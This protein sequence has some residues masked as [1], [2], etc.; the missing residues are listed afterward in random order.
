MQKKTYNS[1]IRLQQERAAA[2]KKKEDTLKTVL[3][4]AKKNPKFIKLLIYSL[5]SLENF[6]SPPN[7]E[8]PINAKII[9]R[10]EG[11]GILRALALINITND[12]VVLKTGDIIWK[13]ISVYD[14][15]DYELAKYFAEK[16]GHQAA[17]EI[18]ISKNK[19]STDNES[20]AK[21][22]IPFIKV[23]NGL[24]QIPQLMNKLLENNL[25][26]TIKLIND[27]YIDDINILN[28]NSD[29]T[30]KVSNLK[31]G[32]D[33]ILK[34]GLIP[35]ILKNL[36][37][38][39]QNRQ[40][41]SVINNFTTLENIARNDEGKNEIK[42]CD[43]IKIIAEV[44]D[45]F[46]END[47]I[48]GKGEK[49]YTKI[50]TE[51]DVK[52]LVENLKNAN[53]ENLG[54][55]KLIMLILSNVVLVEEFAKIVYEN[56]NVIIDVYN[57]V[58]KNKSD[59]ENLLLILRYF[60]ILF[61]RIFAYY[62]NEYYYSNNNKELISNITKSI[63]LIP[64]TFSCKNFNDF[65][66]AYASLIYQNFKYQIFDKEVLIFILEKIINSNNNNN[67]NENFNFASS[68][69]FKILAELAKNDEKLLE[70]LLKNIEF[71]KK[72]I[73]NSEDKQTL[74]N[75]FSCLLILIEYSKDSDKIKNTEFLMFIF[76]FMKNKYYFRR[77]NLINLTI[78][79]NF[80]EKILKE[81]SKE[82]IDSINAVC[83]NVDEN[84]I[85]DENTEKEIKIKSGKLLSK[86]ITEE[87]FKKMIDVFKTN[88]DKFL[89]DINKNDFKDVESNLIYFISILNIK[90]FYEIGAKEITIILKNLLEKNIS[91]IESFKRFKQNETNPNYKNILETNNKRIKLEINLLKVL[92]ENCRKNFNKENKN[93]EEILKLILMCSLLDKYNEPNNLAYFLEE[94][95]NSVE[96]INETYINESNATNNVLI[97]NEKLLTSLIKLSNK[98]QDEKNLCEILIKI[99][100]KYVNFGGEKY[101]NSLVKG[102]IPR[103]LILIMENIN[104]YEIVL[105]SLILLKS[106]AFSNQENLVMLSNQNILLNLFSIKEKF[107]NYDEIT[108]I[109]DEISNEILKIPG[110]EKYA[111]NIVEENIKEFNKEM[112]NDYEKEDTKKNLLNCL[113]NINAFT[114]TKKQVDMLNEKTFTENHNVLIEKTAKDNTLSSNLEKILTNEIT[115]LKKISEN[116]PNDEQNKNIIEN[117]TKII[118]NKSN[119]N[120]IFLQAVKILKVYINDEALYNKYLKTVVNE[121]FIDNLLEVSENFLDNPTILKEINN[122][123][124]LIAIRNPSLSDYIVSKGGLLNVLEEL[125]ENININDENAST[126]KMNNLRML[127][128]LLNDKNNI[129]KFKKLKGENILLNLIKN[130]VK[131]APKTNERIQDKTKLF[132][133][134][135]L[136]D[137]KDTN[138]EHP[139]VLRKKLSN[140]VYIITFIL[141]IFN[142]LNSNNEY[143]TDE[144][145]K[146]IL[147][148]NIVVLFDAYYPNK[149]IY[150]EINKFLENNNLT[151]LNDLMLFLKLNLSTKANYF[152]DEE[153][154][155]TLV[156][157]NNK[158]LND[159]ISKDEYQTNLIN[160]IK[161]NKEDDLTE[162]EKILTYLTIISEDEKFQNTIIKKFPNE[163]KL[164]LE[165][166]TEKNVDSEN[167]FTVIKFLKTLIKTET[168]DKETQTKI[169]TTILNKY[170][171][172]NNNNDENYDLI[173]K[174]LYEIFEIYGK[175]NDL[176]KKFNENQFENDLNYLIN[177]RKNLIPDENNQIIIPSVS[178]NL[179]S[180]NKNN[181]VS[182][183][184]TSSSIYPNQNNLLKSKNKLNK[185]LINVNSHYEKVDKIDEE[186]EKKS[187]EL[188][189]S[190][191]DIYSVEKNNENENDLKTQKENSENIF[192]IIDSILEK[193]SKF[194]KDENNVE[195]IKY[196]IT[197]LNEDLNI[198][199]SLKK[200]IYLAIS[201]SDLFVNN[202]EISS[203]IF[204][205]I[206]KENNFTDENNIKILINLSKN[207]L[208]SKKICQENNNVLTI[209]KKANPEL[210]S[211]LLKNI[212][213]NNYN[214]DYLIKNNPEIIEIYL[215][216]I[217]TK[218]TI[219]IEEIE[220]LVKILNDSNTFNALNEKKILNDENTKNIIEI[221]KSN[222]EILKSNPNLNENVNN[223]ITTLETSNKTLMEKKKLKNDEENLQEIINEINGLYNNHIEQNNK[224]FKSKRPKQPFLRKLS[225]DIEESVNTKL[226]YKTNPK[227]AEIANKNLIIIKNNFNDII[228]NPE[229]SDEN[230]KRK[231][232]LINNSLKNLK[233][234]TSCKDNCQ[235][236]IDSGFLNFVENLYNNKN[237]KNLTPEQFNEIYQN[238]KEILAECSNNTNC[239]EEILKNET[240][241]NEIIQEILN[242]YEKHDNDKNFKNNNQIFSNLCKNKNGY[243]KIFKKIGSDKI[244]NIGS[245][246]A[247]N[248]QILESI[249]VM[250]IYYISNEEKITDENKEKI[251]NIINKSLNL[252]EKNSLLMTN[253]NNLILKIYDKNYKEIFTK[254]F[255]IEHI[256]DE[257]DSFKSDL[258]Y[259][260]SVLKVLIILC[261]DDYV[262]C[263]K[264][265]KSGLLEKI[266]NQV[267]T[268]NENE[269]FEIF[270]NL[271][272]LYL[273]ILNN[274][275]DFVDALVKNGI[276]D[277]IIY[278]LDLFNKK[279]SEN[280]IMT[281]VIN[282]I[283]S[284]TKSVKM[285]N[286]KNEENSLT[287]ST[288]FKTKKYGNL[289][290]SIALKK[291][292]SDLNLKN[293]LLDTPKQNKINFINDILLNCINSLDQVT[294][295]NV[296]DLTESEYYNSVINCLK[297]DSNN[298]IFLNVCLHSLGNYFYNK[299]NNDKINFDELYNI[300]NNYQDKFYNNE[301]IL[302]NINFISGGVIN[303]CKIDD[304]KILMFYNLIIDSIKCQDFNK[305][306]ILM[307]LLLI[308]QILLNL[309]KNN[310]KLLKDDLFL[311]ENC[312]TFCDLINLYSNNNKIKIL[313]FSILTILCKEFNFDSKKNLVEIIKNSFDN[314]LDNVELKN[315]ILNLIQNLID[316]KDDS[317]NELISNELIGS[318]ILDLLENLNLKEILIILSL[319]KMKNNIESFINYNGLGLLKKILKTKN[320]DVEIILNVLNICQFIIDSG[321]EYKKLLK[322]NNLVDCINEAILNCK[323]N[324]D[325]EYLGKKIIYILKSNK[326]DFDFDSYQKANKN[327]NFND[328]IVLKNFVTK[329]DDS[330]VKN[331]FENIGNV[332]FDDDD[333]DNEKIET[334]TIRKKV[335]IKRIVNKDGEVIKEEKEERYDED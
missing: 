37:K 261:E 315:E 25:T 160:T 329:V 117:L 29:T 310:N 251:L 65:F 143:V 210:Y 1:Y 122:L 264:T 93:Y 144:K 230:K 188:I 49:I 335:Y 323:Y 107:A 3:E 182:T 109:C 298:V 249:S 118:F 194:L 177:Y 139:D 239:V 32:R 265:I 219:T 250:L 135:K 243:E 132:K 40:I 233:K 101:A 94:I 167:L 221:L 241:L 33:E 317:I 327:I 18:L 248:P 223:L 272:K 130:E 138:E 106:I 247:E 112:K 263:V 235:L 105:N 262:N 127:K 175:E 195:I 71:I 103:N 326:I 126:N 82:M 332:N 322:Q 76:N 80:D 324:K 86:V 54:E 51:E 158:Y 300:L 50:C 305:D 30:K 21:C 271:T 113:Q 102:G 185:S 216:E 43:G 137:F 197:Y 31:T 320:V 63:T 48:L 69:I 228:N 74:F 220:I 10:L 95:Y 92:L 183:N 155:E 114:L 115:I 285:E 232:D 296:K 205:A 290:K 38:S 53:K 211:S 328:E 156:K 100:N 170:Y 295:C 99:F 28:M 9:I 124:C 266:K 87:D 270:F 83:V 165:F 308:K 34:K 180:N 84:Y 78:L 181:V 39:A 75:L 27:T 237:N 227:I 312:K 316:S 140:E 149:N 173:T 45:I 284:L 15:L 7:R 104:T 57:S 245:A 24:S 145:S 153:I 146:E 12:E 283:F 190:I 304:D 229:I 288:T 20:T 142:Q 22:S 46:T 162:N 163:F 36:V 258:D 125:K 303:N 192:K 282:R 268:I 278:L 56:I 19:N 224:I 166:F 291:K 59:N 67:N 89:S 47:E 52:K 159:I 204:E 98:F 110:Q 207:P 301:D 280:K 108:N 276:V 212:I 222:S 306:L 96:F 289:I 202:E 309:N 254:I 6:V 35:S 91:H 44:L 297:N 242:S 62:P 334:K 70:I 226:N 287:K 26:D 240:I 244:F 186:K 174:E 13:L 128:T 234:L 253:I 73:E 79:E 279:N 311:E 255:V 299:T 302:S 193:D 252:K 218:K 131:I 318:L 256:I 119:Y 319:L 267:E 292:G 169:L 215:K 77:A 213:N 61:K 14:I 97:P 178:M 5:N 41:K 68:L 16:N 133:T 4:S 157:S 116:D 238:T 136:I 58:L 196:I 123:L 11:I 111:D 17:I 273:I 275:L 148:H 134:R 172:L 246:N 307:N 164:F 321:E 152:N 331:Y 206:L 120:E 330:Q 277:N 8:I 217:I 208:I 269:N 150:F 199:N 225:N 151:N 209:I 81:K 231:L 64:E 203:M 72:I 184:L 168:I 257:F 201:N 2:L 176:Y 60:M 294:L 147:L 129:E 121:K 281:N 214:I 236:I 141:E 161:N 187:P 55:I 293:N 333:Y 286:E 274:D 198:P 90:K 179:K 191:I 66:S 88:T 171:E 85:E 189:N 325:V 260:L 42:K 154:N 200:K 314:N 259:L 313:A 23:L